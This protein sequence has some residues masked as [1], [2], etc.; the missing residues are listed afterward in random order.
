M[1]RAHSISIE[2]NISLDKEGRSGKPEDEMDVNLEMRF[3]DDLSIIG[4]AAGEAASGPSSHHLP[5]PGHWSS[6]G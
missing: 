4:Y 6:P 2:Q 5:L 3:G 1:V